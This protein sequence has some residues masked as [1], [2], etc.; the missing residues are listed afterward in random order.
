MKLRKN[1]TWEYRKMNTKELAIDTA[2]QRDLDKKKIERMAKK[3][4]ACLVNAIKVSHRD[5]KY[6]IFDGQHTAI[7][8]KKVRNKGNDVMV[9]V[10]V[11]EGLTR[12]DEMELFVEQNGEATG[13]NANDKLKALWNFG[14]PDVTGMVNAAQCAGVRVDFTRSQAINKVN[15]VSTLLRVYLR[16]QKDNKGDQFIDMLYVLRSAWDG[17]PD[18]FQRE[19]LLGMEKFYQAYYGEF[20][21]KDLIKNLSKV[22]PNYIV[23]E[24]KNV[25][26][27][28]GA[29]TTYAR[30]ILKEYNNRRS[31]KRL[32]DKL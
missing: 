14:D 15:A 24:G 2:Y 20:Q 25:G 21:T 3:Y 31:A 5:G 1:V 26:A 16:F 12:L 17:I 4:D 27:S 6:F 9:D 32:E 22:T 30:V 28:S 18:S 11:F 29:T 8:E 13:V 19:L 7:L 23:R 10:K